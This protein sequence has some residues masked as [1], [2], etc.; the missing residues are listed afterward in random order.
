MRALFRLSGSVCDALTNMDA[1]VHSKQRRTTKRY[2]ADDSDSDD[3]QP[4]SQNFP[5]FVRI[6]PTG[7]KT[8]SDSHLSGYRKLCEL[9][10]VLSHLSEKPELLVE[11]TNAHYSRKLLTLTDLA[12]V[13]VRAEPHR[14]LNSC[15]KVI[16]CSDLKGL[17]KYEIIEGLRSQGVTD[18]FNITV[19]SDNNNSDRRK[20]NTF[21]LTF[22][23]ATAPAHISVVY[24]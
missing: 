22:N 14:T 16:K 15:R 18:C 9:T 13:P 10:L 17:T 8:I 2:K 23:T 21:I 3:S 7:S 20:T 5:K 6:I 11:T 4:D 24:L 12:G 19:K 1:D